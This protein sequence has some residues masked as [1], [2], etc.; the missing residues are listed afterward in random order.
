M[1]DAGTLFT[2]PSWMQKALEIIFLKCHHSDITG[3]DW[4]IELFKNSDWNGG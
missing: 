4:G 2:L 3:I 1:K